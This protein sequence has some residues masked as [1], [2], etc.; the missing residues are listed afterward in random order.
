MIA[1]SFHPTGATVRLA[2]LRPYP[3]KGAEFAVHF[4]AY[5][6]GGGYGT[7]FLSLEQAE[8]LYAQ[9]GAL[10]D[11]QPTAEAV[12]AALNMADTILE[13]YGD[14]VHAK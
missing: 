13:A 9:I 8:A 10:L 1:T 6:D 7:V 5:D 3:G 4:N 11:P 2:D 12:D 14:G